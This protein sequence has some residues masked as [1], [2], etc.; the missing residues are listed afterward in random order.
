LGNSVVSRKWSKFR[1]FFGQSFQLQP[2]RIEVQSGATISGVTI[3]AGD[4]ITLAATTLAF[5]NTSLS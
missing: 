1:H 4:P 3:P 2:G 5:P